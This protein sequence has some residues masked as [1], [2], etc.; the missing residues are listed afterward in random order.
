M[1]LQIKCNLENLTNLHPEPEDFRWYLK[2]KCQSCGEVSPNF[3][4]LTQEE[5]SELKGNRSYA[6]LVSKCKLCH[7][8]NSIN[9]LPETLKSYNAD[10]S[11]NFKTIIVFDCRGYLPVE[12]EFLGGWLAQ[13][14][15]SGTKFEVDLKEKEWAD[16]DEKSKS[17]VGI[18]ELEHQFVKVN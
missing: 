3:Q 4:Y 5:S 8:E 9:I 6:N 15:E 17:S 16:Y 7:R 12:F 14:E 2:L 11:E 10:D 18:Y 13:G 1:G